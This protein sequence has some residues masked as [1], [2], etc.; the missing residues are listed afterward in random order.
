M[1]GSTTAESRRSFEQQAE[2]GRLVAPNG[3]SDGLVFVPD[4]P[5]PFGHP[6]PIR[7]E[8]VEIPDPA[9]RRKLLL[10]PGMTGPVPRDQ[11]VHE[12]V[13]T[14]GKPSDDP[15]QQ[16]PLVLVAPDP[17]PVEVGD[18][19][20][21]AWGQKSPAIACKDPPVTMAASSWVWAASPAWSSMATTSWPATARAAAVVPVPDPSSSIR[22]GSDPECRVTASTR[23][24]G[25][26]PTTR[27][28][29]RL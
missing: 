16:S 26:A 24:S 21:L 7:I 22:R 20:E 5:H 1:K 29:Q 28:M 8:A 9:P 2:V 4:A 12:S 17:E 23:G 6:A 3:L 13:P 27:G 18:D 14:R 11:H 15:T 10:V 19:V 25:I